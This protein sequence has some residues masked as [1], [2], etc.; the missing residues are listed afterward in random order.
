MA[1]AKSEAEVVFKATD[2]GLK[3]TLKD[4]TAEMT[5]NNAEA[6]LVQAQMK[7]TGSET[8][9]LS[10]N[11]SSLEKSYDLQ[12]QKIQVTSER[13]ENAKKYYGE[14]S[15]EVQRLEKELINQQTAQQNLANKITQTSEALSK[16]KGDVKDYASTMQSLDDEQKNIQASAALVESE[17]KKW[18]ATAGQTATESE[19]LAKAQDYVAQQSSLAEQKISVM[20]RQLQ[21]TQ[22]EFGATST[23][24]MQMQAKLNDAESEFE[25]LGQAAKSI[26][27]S[28]LDDIG[29]KIDLGNL[30][31]AS[32][33]LSDI[34]DKMM[35]LGQNAMESA[36]NVGSS[37]G[38]IQANFGLTKEEAEKLTAVAKDIYHKGFGESLG[39]VT[40]ALVLAKRNLGDLNNQ[41][42]QNITEQ[43]MVLEETM[44]SDM[45]E[46]LR[47][48]NSLMSTYG[49]T[50]QQAMDL[51]VV[52]TQ[53]GLDKTHELGDNLAEYAPLFE[54]SGYS[55]EEMF[56]I[57]QSGLDGGAY[58]LDKVNDL[59][60]EFGIRMSDGTV[61]TAVEDLGGNFQSLFKEIQ[62]GGM[63]NKDAFQMLASEISNLGSEQEKAAA[64]SAIFG[65]QG[66]DAGIKV[67]DAMQKANTTLADNKKAFEDASGA[68]QEMNDA[69]T[70]PMQELNGKLAELKDSLAPIGSTIIE[71]LGPIVD[72]LTDLSEAF[73]N[74]SPD[75][76]QV[77][78]IVGGLAAGFTVLAPFISSMVTIFQVLG[79]LLMGTIV[80]AIGGLITAIVPF[81]P[82]IAAVVAAVGAAILIF[83]NWGAITDWI[84]EKWT[85]F[86]D[87]I[88]GLWEGI[89]ETASNVWSAIK[90]TV[91]NIVSGTIEK[92]KNLWDGLKNWISN[93]WNSIKTVASNVWNAIKSTVTNLISSAVN[94]A[95]N[96]WNGLKDTVSNIWE[97][98][99]G[100]ASN[101]WNGIKSVISNAIEGAKNTVGNI[102]NGIK[103]IISNVFNG[104]KST[105]SDVW[106]GIKSAI[107]NPIETAKNVVS[108]IIDKIKGLFNFKL[109][110][111]E[112][113]IPNIPLPHFSI[114][115]SFNPL[116]G[117]LPSVGIK[118]YAKGGLFNG[119]SVIGVGEAGKEAVLPLNDGVLG[120][121]G[122]MIS[123]NMP[124][125]ST[126]SNSQVINNQFHLEVNGNIDSEQTARRMVDN[127]MDRITEKFNNQ[128]TAFN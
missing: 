58:N 31:E 25:Q 73:A 63:S 123:E 19:K 29:S 67:I 69:S 85:V 14:N 18:Q 105:V 118:W 50:A 103:T 101:V 30:M 117:E 49:L 27:T 119:P 3:S 54:D 91:S 78:V 59:V 1:K 16:A 124:A 75:I 9:K 52:G 4:I 39:Q 6:K 70:T 122:R 47:G 13:L 2:D 21:A 64:I 125:K 113:S 65:S 115:G 62:D 89:K 104:I 114:S 106:N 33:V 128:N 92:V 109:K 34:G 17:Y 112:I 44:G 24:A 12:S 111:P 96:L 53:N 11:L 107:T 66:E 37:Q 61:A 77:I 102:V 121:I 108:G 87:W 56:A 90:T 68:A 22:Q 7:L 80:P 38:K 10:S 57:L 120:T 36:D 97:G 55:A 93:L 81:L 26:D 98:I 83:K 42:L 23:E 43:A 127:L 126:D 46:S 32:D 100:T 116:K 41:D 5:K 48:V 35:E 74:L 45:D 71:A 88:S 20:A 51:L 86:K 8:D 79:P 15:T 40:D 82:I 99:K 84:S 28:E 94:T 72:F 95:K 60:K 110:F 76:Q